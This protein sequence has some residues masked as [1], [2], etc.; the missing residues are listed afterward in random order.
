MS[1][2][3]KL[4]LAM[5]GMT[6]NILIGTVGFALIERISFFDSLWMTMVSLLTVGYGDL[7]PTTIEGKTF[8]LIIIPIGIGLVAYAL[9]V[10]AAGIIEGSF[11]ISVRRKRMEQA[12]AK[13][14]GHIIVCGWGRVGQQVVE[15]LLQAG[16]SVV[17]IECEQDR[18]TDLPKELFYIIGNA[19]EDQILYK[20][21]IERAAGLVATLPADADNVFITLTAK[22]LNPSIKVVSRVER[23]ESEEKLRRAGADKVINPSNISGR[24]MALSILKPGSIDYVDTI[25]QS[26]NAAFEV[27]EITLSPDSPLVGQTLS[28]SSIR[29]E[30]GVTIAAI[31]RGERIISNPLSSE[32]LAMGDELIVFGTPE[33][34]GR[35]EKVSRIAN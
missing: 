29:Q 6:I 11:S 5:L 26:A 34:L 3:K 9:G 27:E 12:I 31:K 25:L 8:A 13:L 4:M 17:V 18:I 32:K 16:K 10:M 21:G 1:I 20:A 14:Q 2:N 30:Y 35:F 7:Y 22:G 24:R 15:Q 33:Q 28:E 19:T 23:P